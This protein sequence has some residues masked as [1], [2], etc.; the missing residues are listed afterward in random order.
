VSWVGALDMSGSVWEWVSSLYLPYD[1]QQ[2]R[3]ADTGAR[4]DVLSVL[5]GGSWG[6][7]NAAL[8]RGSDRNRFYPDDRDVNYGFRCAR[9]A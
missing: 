2:S 7:V 3:E 4:T 8:F 1:S 5:R 6:R 9:S